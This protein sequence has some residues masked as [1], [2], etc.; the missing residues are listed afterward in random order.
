MS[1]LS[2][3]ER[4]LARLIAKTVDLKNIEPEKLDPEASLFGQQ[5]GGLGLDSI[6]A[7]EIAMIVGKEYGVR[8]RWDDQN[9]REIFRSLQ[10]LA[11][12][13]EQQRKQ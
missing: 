5:I 3:F 9:N 6:D 12:H 10:S 2:D 4:E 13:I 1:P 7:L 11:R 8:L